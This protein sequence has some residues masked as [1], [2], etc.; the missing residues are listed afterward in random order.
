MTDVISTGLAQNFAHIVQHLQN[1]GLGMTHI[2][3]MI[4]YT[5]TSQ[6]NNSLENRSMLSTKAILTM[7]E[8]FNVNPIYLFL[9]KGEMFLTEEDEPEFTKL[10]N[11]YNAL[12]KQYSDSLVTIMKL[13]KRNTA[14][15]TLTRNIL[16]DTAEL[17]KATSEFQKDSVDQ[18]DEQNNQH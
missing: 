17:M 10:F 5:S 4:G 16:M 1:E 12:N 14:L 13:E 6:L 11:A 9:G 8:R 18:K 7:I 15:E 3:K 2:A